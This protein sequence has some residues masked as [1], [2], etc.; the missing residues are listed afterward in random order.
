M[1][2]EL[3]IQSVREKTTAS[4]IIGRVE[5]QY[6]KKA[7]KK[8]GVIKLKITVVMEEPLWH[9]LRIQAIRE[10]ATASEIIGKLVVGYLKKAKKKGGKTKWHALENG[11]ANGWLTGGTKAAS[12]TSR[13]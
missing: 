11:A 6:L 4:E 1:W 13:Q 5:A 12:A 9:E 8:G 10:K 2:H 3:R 7:G